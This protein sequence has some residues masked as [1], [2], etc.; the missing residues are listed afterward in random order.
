[1]SEKYNIEFNEATLIAYINGELSASDHDMVE[2][3]LTL[4]EDN[5]KELDR[6][7]KIWTEA[8]KVTP[9]PVYVDTDKALSKVLNQ[10]NQGKEIPS[11]APKSNFR[12]ILFSAAAV[13]V[14]LFGAVSVINFFNESSAT[15]I[16]LTAENS[17]LEDELSD[18]TSVSI[19]QNS[20]L[21]YPDKFEGKERRVKLTG[22]AFFDVKRDETKP[23]IIDLHNDFYVKVLGTSFNINANDE[24]SLTEVYVKSGKVEFGS[25]KDKVI[26]IAGETGVMNNST[27]KVRKVIVENADIK[28]LYW[29]TEELNFDH[30]KLST[31]L[32]ILEDV[33]EVQIDLKCQDK[34]DAQLVSNHEKES[35]DEI[36]KVISSLHDLTLT[37]SKLNYTLSCD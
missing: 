32:I 37:K 13:I 3:W 36:L 22:E 23:F 14:I 9:S 16:E 2:H 12:R 24:D 11:I 33:F 35:L 27:G 21:I 28:S 6:I 29:K 7:K 8:E 31:A 25:E 17:I 19:N 5:Q 18:G 10:I 30:M 26:L 34:M 1:M 4:S 20:M 15:Q